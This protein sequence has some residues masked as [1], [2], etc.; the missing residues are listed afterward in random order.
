MKH[1]SQ[2]L[3]NLSIPSDR[4]SAKQNGS[5]DDEDLESITTELDSPAGEPHGTDIFRVAGVPTGFSDIDQLTG[6]LQPSDLVVVASRSSIGKTSLALGMTYGAAMSHGKT[7]AF[8]TL[9]SN[10]EQ[11]ISR[12]IAM[13]TGVAAISLRLGQISDNEWDRISRAVGRLSEA[14][15]FVDD[16]AS[17]IM[18][19]RSKARSL[20]AEQGLDLIVVD[21][22]Q[23]VE[24]KE[25][26]DRSQIL[27][28]ASK[29]LKDLACELDIPVVVLSQLSL[30][31]ESRSDRRPLLSDLRETGSLGND[32][33]VVMFIYREDRYEADSE[34]RGVAEIIVAKHRHG[35]VG[36]INLRFFDRTTRFTDLELYPV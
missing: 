30:E 28:E 7:V 24:D 13:E 4:S 14:S 22:I 9:E 34:K 12:L 27:S 17:S 29:A 36:S 16:T 26:I 19:I 25:G 1:I 33:D 8:F 18:D 6:G 20:K 21:P 32:A 11:L 3:Q 35:P 5:S 2:I 10:S 23:L 15:I 31:M